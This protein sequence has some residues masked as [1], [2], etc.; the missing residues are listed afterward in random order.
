MELEVLGWLYISNIFFPRVATEK[1]GI[2]HDFELLLSMNNWIVK[3]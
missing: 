3:E 1:S 2:I